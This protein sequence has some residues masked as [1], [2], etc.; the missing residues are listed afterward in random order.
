MIGT[1]AV[2]PSEGAKNQG[3]WLVKE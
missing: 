2:D 3:R 1:V